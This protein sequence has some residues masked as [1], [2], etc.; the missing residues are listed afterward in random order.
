[1]VRMALLDL[2]PQVW[3]RSPSPHPDFLGQSLHFLPQRAVPD[4]GQLALGL[5]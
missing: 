3:A 2:R 4:L 5:S 1:M